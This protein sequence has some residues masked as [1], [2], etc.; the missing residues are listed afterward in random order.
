MRWQKIVKTLKS[1]TK[2][3]VLC[4]IIIIILNFA[5]KPA[6]NFTII[7]DPIEEGWLFKTKT[8]Q[9][10]LF[11]HVHFISSCSASHP[12]W[13]LLHQIFFINHANQ[14]KVCGIL[15]WCNSMQE[16][17]N[18]KSS[19]H[20]ENFIAVTDREFV[21]SL[22]EISLWIILDANQNFIVNFDL[23]R[24]WFAIC[25]HACRQVKKINY[26]DYLRF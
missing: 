4:T 12:S 16:E 18:K 14:N 3:S 7:F 15:C 22:K 26:D 10:L 20:H 24:A 9:I 5:F 6:F 8:L 21:K 1:R 25:L 2:C 19:Y 11:D 23:P 17:V 13:Q